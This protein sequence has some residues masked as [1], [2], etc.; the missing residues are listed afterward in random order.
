MICL[1]CFTDNKSLLSASYVPDI[2][3]GVEDPIVSKLIHGFS[4]PGAHCP[5]QEKD[6]VNNTVII[7]KEG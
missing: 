3:V 7:R 4:I 1:N 5:V 6:T 2:K